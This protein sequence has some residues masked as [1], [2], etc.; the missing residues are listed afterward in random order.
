MKYLLP[1]GFIQVGSDEMVQ[2]YYLHPSFDPCKIVLPKLLASTI[3]TSDLKL[4][5]F[6][7]G[8][9]VPL[10]VFN[11][12]VPTG[13]VTKISI[14]SNVL[15]LQKSMLLESI[16]A[17]TQSKPLEQRFPNCGTRTTCGTRRICRW[18]A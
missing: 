15:A 11:D 5:S 2:F 18:Y 4:H 13:Y 8:V 16:D 14:L 9:P 17:S 3:L 7:H 1:K 10:S 6:V 12:L